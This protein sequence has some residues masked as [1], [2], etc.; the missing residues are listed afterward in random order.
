MSDTSEWWWV[1]QYVPWVCMAYVPGCGLVLLSF[2]FIGMQV[3][4]GMIAGY[5][6]SART[7]NL[8]PGWGLLVGAGIGF[9]SMFAYLVLR[10]LVN[11]TMHNRHHIDDYVDPIF[12]YFVP[13][14]TVIIVVVATWLLCR[15]WPKLKAL[16]RGVR[17]GSG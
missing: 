3:I 16:A 8:V 13:P 4:A 11:E 14:L 15:R 9:L 10:V 17:R 7:G 2:W 6:T 1:F 5:R 12:N